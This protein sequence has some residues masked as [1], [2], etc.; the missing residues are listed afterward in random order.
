MKERN[1]GELL[2]D[3]LQFGKKID[4]IVTESKAIP[5]VDKI[6]NQ[7][8]TEI[9]MTTLETEV[10]KAAILK[11]TDLIIY[12]VTKFVTHTALPKI[13]E[14]MS[15]TTDIS[16][17]GEQEMYN[18]LGKELL[19]KE[20]TFKVIQTYTEQTLSKAEAFIKQE[21]YAEKLNIDKLYG[22]QQG[23]MVGIALEIFTN[24]AVDKESYTHIIIVDDNYG[25][26]AIAS[27]DPKNLIKEG[28]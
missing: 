9:H 26:I 20:E 24:I 1:Y 27:L 23:S 2:F 6:R 7:V 11:S 15:K 17:L 28:E 16:K 10:Q 12:T 22:L 5:L 13:I 4:S 14:E 3:T 18:T 8:Y 25:Y 21:N 19:N